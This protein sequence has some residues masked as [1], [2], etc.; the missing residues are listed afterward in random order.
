MKED[1]QPYI[2]IY[3]NCPLPD[4]LYSSTDEWR[5]H[6]HMYHST[7]TWEC[8]VCVQSPTYIQHFE[9]A[10][11]MEAH[12]R[13]SHLKT[14]ILTDSQV[15]VAIDK[16]TQSAPF[17]VD[18]CP[19]CTK[20]RL[21]LEE[22]GAGDILD[23]IATEL[24]DLAFEAVVRND[25]LCD[26]SGGSERANPQDDFSQDP[27]AESVSGSEMN[28]RVSVSPSIEDDQTKTGLQDII[29]PLTIKS[30]RKVSKVHVFLHKDAHDALNS[31]S[32]TN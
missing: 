24:L 2:C 20:T 28:E 13:S 10:A 12:L 11:E 14:H 22:E 4:K 18:I 19:I 27:R 32:T 9:S 6:I 26:S 17:V 25:D 29:P 21:Q 5:K 3:E 30:L 16:G 23:H 7:M 31:F 15:D 8:S 1:L